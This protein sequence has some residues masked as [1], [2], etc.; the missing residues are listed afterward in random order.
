M[1]GT[2]TCAGNAFP[3][4]NINILLYIK[5]PT[6]ERTMTEHHN[7]IFLHVIPSLDFRTKLKYEVK[8]TK[9]ANNGI[10]SVLS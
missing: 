7:N 2:P 10:M 6:C 5:K 8:M 3:G 4:V 9:H 1:I